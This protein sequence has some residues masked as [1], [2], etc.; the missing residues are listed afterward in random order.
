MILII[1]FKRR[2]SVNR[3]SNFLAARGRA[4]CAVL[5][6]ITYLSFS[7]IMSAAGSCRLT[8]KG[9]RSQDLMN[10]FYLNRFILESSRQAKLAQ[11]NYLSEQCAI[12]VHL[13]VRHLRFLMKKKTRWRGKF[14]E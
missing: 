14:V 12:N 7:V 6:I 10:S 11:F 1:S 2:Y 8:L 13:C 4:R 9:I 5:L 3:Y